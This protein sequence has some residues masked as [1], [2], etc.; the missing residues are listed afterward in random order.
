M[1]IYERLVYYKVVFN[2][3]REEN[4]QKI[5]FVILAHFSIPC[6]LLINSG[7]DLQPQNV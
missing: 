4:W 5:S 3:Q 1:S 6:E 7:F 2:K